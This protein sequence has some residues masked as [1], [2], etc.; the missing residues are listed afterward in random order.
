MGVASSFQLAVG[1]PSMEFDRLCAWATAADEAGFAFVAVGDN[2]GHMRDTYVALTLL[3]QS[4]HRCNVGTAMTNPAHRDVLVV[5]SAV[6]SIETLAPGRVFLG[7]GRGRAHRTTSVDSLRA[8]IVALRQLWERGET[9]VDGER[10][11][12]GWDAR[13]VP[14]VV[15]GSGP[16]VLQLAGELADGVIV[17]SGVSEEAIAFARRNLS[18]GARAAGRDVESLPVWW[19]LKASIAPDR[20]EA[21]DMALAPAAASGALVLG[22]DPAGRGVPER[23]RARCRVLRDRYDISA[24]LKTDG[25]DPNKRLLDDPALRSYLFDRFAIVG[26]AA[27]W[28]ARIDHLRTQGVERV[29]LAAVVPDPGALIRLVGT[30]VIPALAAPAL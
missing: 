20:D 17:E 21:I 2:P 7:I 27:D 14:I 26:T 23:F 25:D 22:A 5:A 19:Y 29:F 11:T 8:H 30:S 24:H 3:A 9:L 10:L 18:E 12:L 6:A 4:T 1:F 13:P 28:L 16:R 15:G